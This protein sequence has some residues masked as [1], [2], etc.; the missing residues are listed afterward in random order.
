MRRSAKAVALPGAERGGEWRAIALQRSATALAERFATALA[1]ALCVASGLAAQAPAD[2]CEA[3][4]GLKLQ[5]TTIT[6]AAAVTAGSFKPNANANAPAMTV[7]AFCRVAATL[8]PTPESNIRIEVWLPPTAAWNGKFLGTGNG[9]AGGIISYSALANGL[10][11][12]YATTNTDMGTTTTGLDFTFGVGHREMVVDWGYRATHL[13]TQAA[14]QIAKS[15]YQRDAQQSYFMGCSTGGHQALT[16]ARRYPDDYNGIVAGDPANNRVRLHMVSYWN[17]E[18]THND[19][20]SYIPT[21]KLPM[22]NRAV[23][24]AC[25]KID[26]LADAIIDD[27]RR[28]KFDPAAAEC[29]SGSGQGGD[30]AN[31]LTAPQVAALKKIYQGPKNPRTGETIF[32]GMYLGSEVN[33]LGLD[34]TLANTP[35]SGRPRPAPGLAIWTNWKG[36][37]Y[38]WDKDAT[39]V[40]NELSPLL[41]DADPDLTAFK[42]RGGKLL[43]YTGWADPLIPAADLVNYYEGMQKKMGGASATA[44]FARLFMVPGMGH[45]SG[46]TSPNRFDA[47]AALEPWV[48]KGTPP[49]RILAAQIA[50]GATVRTRPLCPYPQ[51]AKWNGTGSSDDAANF[52]CRQP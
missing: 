49:E 24:D 22:I 27:P 48:E 46:G 44:E 11:K 47:L 18:A 50:Q 2:S 35:D 12:G 40:I 41:D 4:S 33:P 15:Y 8:K 39:M 7:P 29:P 31:C 13:M 26:G 10:A 6:T 34:R 1:L 52:T 19:P 43:L 21:S 25:D 17:Y 16:E 38:D 36:P 42:R 14:K 28:C 20:A 5:D 3:L 32:P 30:T 45:C 51:V 9:G 23:L 37:A